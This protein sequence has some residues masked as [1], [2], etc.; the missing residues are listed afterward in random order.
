MA[1]TFE[2]SYACSMPVASAG[3]GPLLIRINNAGRPLGRWGGFGAGDLQFTGG[4]AGE[5]RAGPCGAWA[6]AGCVCVGVRQGLEQGLFWCDYLIVCTV[7]LSRKAISQPC[8]WCFAFRMNQ[9]IRIPAARRFYANA[10]DVLRNAASVA[11][12]KNWPSH[13]I[14]SVLKL[15]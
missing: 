10:F 15:C 3:G 5:T 7:E 12:S 2:K 11:D 14:N 9:S 6:E 1:R 8:V 13:A 4:F